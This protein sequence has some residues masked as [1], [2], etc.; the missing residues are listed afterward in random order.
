MHGRYA[1]ALESEQIDK[2]KSIEWLRSA[3]LKETTEGLIIAPKIRRL[4]QII[5]KIKY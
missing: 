4:Q 2:K 3:G 5:I 1:Q